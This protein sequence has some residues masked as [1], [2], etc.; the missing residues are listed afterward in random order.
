MAA[1]G[2]QAAGAGVN[3]IRLYER[4]DRTRQGPVSKLLG[5]VE[6]P[7]GYRSAI[8]VGIWDRDRGEWVASDTDAD[9]VLCLSINRLAN[10]RV[11]L[12]YNCKGLRRVRVQY[13]RMVRDN[14]WSD[15]KCPVCEGRGTLDRHGWQGELFNRSTES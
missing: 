11:R 3:L 1:S 7:F 8:L 4:T 5:L 10:E 13:G 12:C 9:R 14:V 6:D 15:R 2:S